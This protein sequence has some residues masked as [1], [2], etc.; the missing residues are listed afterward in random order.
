MLSIRDI[1]CLTKATAR[2][3]KPLLQTLIMGVQETPKMVYPTGVALGCL[4]ELKDKSLLLKTPYTSDPGLE[5]TIFF[6]NRAWRIQTGSDPQA[7]SLRT[8]IHVTKGA[9]QVSKGGKHPIV[10]PSCVA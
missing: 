9:M 7:S 4:P 3:G 8:S 2:H 5:D 1:D 6:R 10:L